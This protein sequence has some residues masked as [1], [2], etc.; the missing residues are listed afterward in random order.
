MISR[1]VPL[2][3]VA[4]LAFAAGALVATEAGAAVLK[5]KQ[6]GE[7][8]TGTLTNQK[9][10]NLTVFRL[11]DGATKFINPGEWEVV[12]A[13][14]A[15]SAPESPAASE[16][17]AVLAP[18]APAPAASPAPA[19]RTDKPALVRGYILPISGPIEHYALVEALQKGAT[20]AKKKSAAVVILRMNTPGGRLDLGNKIID[21]IEEIDDWATIVAWVSGNDRQALSCGAYLSFATQ[22]IFMAPGTTIGAATPYRMTYWGPEI[23]EK[24]T[25]AFRARFRSLAQQRG[26]PAP[27]ADAMVDSSTAVIQVFLDGKQMFVS[28]DEAK[29]ME[30]ENKG[31]DRFKRGKTVSGRGKLI[32]FTD[33][34]AL[35]FEVCSAIVSTGEEIMKALGHES[36]VVEEASWLPGWVEAESR[37]RKA[38]FERYKSQFDAAVY[39]ANTSWSRIGTRRQLEQAAAAL[40][41]IEQMAADPRMDIPITPEDLD[42]MKAQIQGWYDA[43][44]NP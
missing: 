17:P 30:K 41:A 43:P 5:H 15:A 7:T 10:N 29:Q 32:T 35:E 22:K 8:I 26:Y 2:A 25:S 6:T 3:V 1:R 39:E 14:E 33:Q 37:K 13:D 18:V 9:I 20:E 24:L 16:S 12:K 38:L 34:E 4:A 21:L 40:K 31:T 23:E 28:D 27:I 42:K 44:K 11:E 19:A 36:A